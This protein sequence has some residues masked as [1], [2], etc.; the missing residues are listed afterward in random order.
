PDAGA[1]AGARA[2][3]HPH[4]RPLRRGRA[5]RRVV[6]G[7]G[8]VVRPRGR[9]SDSA[10]RAR[11]AITALLSAIRSPTAKQKEA[12]ARYVHTLWAAG[13]IGSV[14]LVFSESPLTVFAAGRAGAMPVLAVVL[15]GA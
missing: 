7:A 4:A 10:R 1:Q 6:R 11:S 9:K 15:F 13:A 14:S 8:V 3:R 5:S 2:R 12:Y